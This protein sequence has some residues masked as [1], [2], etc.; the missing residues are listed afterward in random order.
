MK[1]KA[2]IYAIIAILFLFKAN[3]QD[4]NLTLV[5]PAGEDAVIAYFHQFP[6]S[7]DGKKMVFTIFKSDK[8]MEIL[9]KDLET[10]VFFTINTVKGTQ[11]HSGAHPLWVDN[12][13]LV[14]GSNADKKIYLHDIYTG[15]LNEFYGEQ[16][17]DYSCVNNKVLFVN[18]KS[19]KEG[20]FVLDVITK[21][22]ELI[23]GLDAVKGLKEEMKTNIDIDGWNF[24][25]PYFS[26]D[27]KKI[28][29]QI[30]AKLRTKKGKTKKRE[31]YYLFA[32]SN[33]KNI[34]FIGTKPMHIQ[35]WDNESIFGFETNNQSNH[36]MQ[37]YDLNGNVVQ[38]NVVG[39]GN[40]GTVC[41]NRKWIVTDSWYQTDPIIVYLYRKG[42][43]N[44]T[45]VL[46]RQPNIVNGKNFWDVHSHIHPSFSRD[47]KKVYFN[48]MAKDGLSKVWCYDLTDIVDK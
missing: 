19:D 6:E 30:K 45:K 24:D 10:E 43:T 11:R 37:K 34:R 14:Y 46:F 32:D 20:V 36:N 7:P 42:S 33:G 29:F 48:G 12:Q 15:E 2:L 18:K 44:P 39:H 28:M 8:E 23:I 35:W 21:K 26:P 22:T 16:I 5:S 13:T 1:K 31:D 4:E 47:G 25:H 17:S 41:P 27:A 3:S 9:V 38:E 40:H